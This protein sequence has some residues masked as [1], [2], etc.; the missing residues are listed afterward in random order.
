M[1]K[2]LSSNGGPRRT[3]LTKIKYQQFRPNN[4]KGPTRK[5]G[6]YIFLL[7]NFRINI[8]YFLLIKIVDEV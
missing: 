6:Q 1:N 5:N 3:I 7:S 8:S 4:N 2:L